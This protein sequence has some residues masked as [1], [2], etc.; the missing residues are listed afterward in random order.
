MKSTPARIAWIVA[1]VALLALLVLKTREDGAT[2]AAA[3]RGPRAGQGAAKQQ[4]SPEEIFRRA[5]WRQPA[6]ADRILRAER[7][8]WKAGD[9][10]LARW[11]WFLE[12]KP[13]PELLGRLVD[14]EN[15]GLEKVA[16]GTAPRSWM[17]ESAPP[18]PW[19][20][21]PDAASGFEVRQN[22][23]GGFTLL[24]RAD[25]NTLFATDSGQGFAAPAT[26]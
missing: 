16:P 6:A 20:P 3:P 24:Y 11:Q 17:M 26:R 9:G 15:F 14:P 18:P 7:F 23:A 5:F 21:R 13:G 19:F 4:W 8:E 12:L 25:D 10:S 2:D 1:V 22:P